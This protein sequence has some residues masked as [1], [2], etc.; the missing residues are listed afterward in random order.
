MAS[1]TRLGRLFT[2]LDYTLP[3]DVYMPKD[4][5]MGFVLWLYG[6][7]SN[8]DKHAKTLSFIAE[9][10][11]VPV[12]C[13]DYSGHG[14]APFDYGKTTPAQHFLEVIT[15]YDELCA[16]FGCGGG[17]VIGGSYGAYLLLQLLKYRRVTAGILR[18]PALLKPSSFYTRMENI[19][20]DES[21]HWQVDE[22]LI[23]KHPLVNRA[24][25]NDSPMLVI[26]H[27]K[28]ELIPAVVPKVLHEMLAKSEYR[29]IKGLEHSLHNATVKQRQD[30][31]KILLEWLVSA[32]KKTA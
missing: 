8:K 1:I 2:V 30:Y 17:A 31:D 21:L 19:E 11:N 13:F 20:K 28:D 9:G 18:V 25:Q 16:E 14:K 15:V 5:A 29:E 4:P 12:F 6:S 3:G 23:R 26:A 7:A 32:Q 27:E 10:L 22:A 24:S